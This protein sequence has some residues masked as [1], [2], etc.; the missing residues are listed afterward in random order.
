M[1]NTEEPKRSDMLALV[2]EYQITVLNA[3]EDADRVVVQS[4]RS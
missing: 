3:S 2:E 4:Q 1:G